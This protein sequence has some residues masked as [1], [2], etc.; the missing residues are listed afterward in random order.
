MPLYFRLLKKGIIIVRQNSNR[1]TY[2]ICLTALTPAL[3]LA[4]D[5]EEVVVTAS[6]VNQPL[7]SVSSNITRIDAETLARINATHINEA[8]QRVAGAWISR[9]NGQEHLTSLRSPVLTGAGGCGA[10][11][12]AQDGIPLRASGFCNVNELFDAHSEQAGGIEVIKGPAGVVYGANAMHGLVNIL[13]PA[14]DAPRGVSVE[15]GPDDYYRTNVAYGGTKWRADFNGTTDGGYKDESGFD[16][17]KLSIK[18]QSDWQGF[19]I[20]GG[21]TLTNLNQETSG[22]VQG[23]R[24]YKDSNLRTSNPNPEAYRDSKSARLH[25]RLERQFDAGTLVLTPYARDTQMTF[26]QHFL[27]GQAIEENGHQSFG[28]QSAWHQ[29]NW[30][31]GVDL[32]TTDGYLNEFQPGPTVSGSAFLVATIPAGAHYDYDVEASTQA[33]FGRYQLPL[34]DATVISAG[35]RWERVSYDYDN[36]L[37]DGRNREDGTACG[38]GGCRFSRPA[39]RKDTFNQLSSQ[40]GL[41][42]RLT[43][44]RQLYINLSR[45]FRAPQATELY[46]LQTDQQ[47]ADIDVE[48]L[49]S[50]EVGLRGNT[51]DWSF[52][53]SVYAMKKDNF[54]FRDNNRNNVDNGKTTHRG[55]EATVGYEL[56]DDV[57][58]NLFW[59]YARHQYANNP[60]LSQS[61]IDGNDIDTAPRN[62][63]SGNIQ[64]RM[65]T[66]SQIEL[67]WVHMGEYFQDPENNNTYA[68]HDLVNVRLSFDVGDGWQLFGRVMNLTNTEYAER[69]DFAFG[70]DRYFVGQPIS[71]YVGARAAL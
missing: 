48:Q 37:Q 54:I 4:I 67:E 30:L 71:L 9:G 46:R 3:S 13:T 7:A 23:P 26:L 51:G 34:G 19:N 43:Q 40:L 1:L 53:A 42:H 38:F 56:T 17:Q 15:A 36:K 5:L 68:G 24:A 61:L 47:V 22:F 21:L 70:N 69:A 14:I 39:D 64:W 44:D 52:D 55:I 28:L 66:A 2:L 11:L 45:G 50:I 49:D 25:A 57:S 29:D 65:S 59:T 16:Q 12:M 18:T 58:A 63:G 33:L 6:R 20:T 8:M 10:F 31:V 60:A 41:T 32:E 35:A 27:P 62:M